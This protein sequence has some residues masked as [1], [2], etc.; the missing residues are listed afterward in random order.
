MLLNKRKLLRRLLAVTENVN[1]YN[2]DVSPVA[3]E[4]NQGIVT[5][6]AATSRI[7]ANKYFVIERWN[8]SFLVE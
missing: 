3:L 8:E 4:T 6:R 5:M 7:N 2:G 1:A